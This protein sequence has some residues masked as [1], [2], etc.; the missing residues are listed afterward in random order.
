MQR[1]DNFYKKHVISRDQPG[2][3]GIKWEGKT[4]HFQNCFDG[5]DSG[6]FL[7]VF[8]RRNK[9]SFRDFGVYDL[10][11]GGH[12]DHPLPKSIDT[13]GHQFDAPLL[14]PQKLSWC[15]FQ[16]HWP[17]D[18]ILILKAANPELI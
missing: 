3:D 4:G 13:R 14:A 2:L 7:Q 15:L 18:L 5:C 16:G 8:F 11:G 1:G 9:A 17:M 6:G 12:I 10:T